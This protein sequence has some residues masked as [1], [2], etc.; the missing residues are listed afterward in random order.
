MD[1]ICSIHCCQYKCYEKN[2]IEK[3]KKKNAIDFFLSFFLVKLKIKIKTIKLAGM[4]K[5]DRIKKIRFCR[6]RTQDSIETMINR[7]E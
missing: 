2:R 5:L 7:Y 6:Y 3:T 1:Y 4:P